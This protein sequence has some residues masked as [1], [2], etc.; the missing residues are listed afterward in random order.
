MARQL[1]RQWHG[2]LSPSSGPLL[3]HSGSA[4]EACSRQAGLEG[5]GGCLGERFGS[6]GGGGGGGLLLL[7]CC[8]FLLTGAPRRVF[9][10]SATLSSPLSKDAM[11]AAFMLFSL[12]KIA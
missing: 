9:S 11:Y 10:L 1:Q 5:P 7:P 2:N 3:G 4:Q 8:F 12:M 6:H